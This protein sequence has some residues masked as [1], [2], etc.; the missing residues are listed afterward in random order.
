MI[1]GRRPG[2]PQIERYVHDGSIVTGDCVT[3]GIDTLLWLVNRFLGENIA[4][5]CP[6]Q[7]EYF[8]EPPYGK[9]SR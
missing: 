1:D 9:A 3:A 6:T 5:A 2:A 7:V 4:S 8:P